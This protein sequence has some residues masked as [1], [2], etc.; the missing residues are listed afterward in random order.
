MIQYLDL[1]K[2]IVTE[3]EVRE[4]SRPGLPKTRG[5]FSHT[6]EFDLLKDG[7]PILTTK[8]VKFEKVVAELLWFLRGSNTLKPLI[9]DGCNIWNKDGYRFA[10]ETN[11][12]GKDESYE[13]YIKRVKENKHYTGQLGKIYGP[14]WRN[15]NDSFDQIANLINGLRNRPTE[16]YH[17][18]TAW[19]P[20]DFLETKDSAALPACHMMFQ[21]YVSEGRYLDL[22]MIQRSCD[23]FLGVP[24]NITSYALLLTILADLSDL[25]P[26]RFI[27]HG[28]DIHVYENHLD[29]I[30]EQISRTPLPLPSFSNSECY[31]TALD[32]FEEDVEESNGVVTSYILDRF[33]NRIVKED[34]SLLG[35][36]HHPAIKGELS[37]GTNR[38]L[39]SF[40]AEPFIGKTS[41][42]IQELHKRVNKLQKVAQKRG[43]EL[44]LEGEGRDP[45]CVI[46]FLWN[47]DKTSH[48]HVYITVEDSRI[49]QEE[50]L[51]KLDLWINKQ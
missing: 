32:I 31:F 44:E 9:H 22:C 30:N 14:Q 23:T 10:Q 33:L 47:E 12:L 16:R 13:G 35:Y 48:T 4:A 6:M 11:R 39:P 20:S 29:Q 42:T 43:L 19:N 27:W 17:I 8:E 34:F 26:G 28:M 24:F 51:W 45:N 7:F 46:L 38:I 50:A 37:V 41:L 25:L 15:W 3:G 21:C 1:L 40:D 5:I 2:K 49:V 18:V 36:K